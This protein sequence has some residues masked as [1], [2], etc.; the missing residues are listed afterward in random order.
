MCSSLLNLRRRHN[1]PSCL[2]MYKDQRFKG[3]H[4]SNE[5]RDEWKARKRAIVMRD[6]FAMRGV[7]SVFRNKV[8][9]VVH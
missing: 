2:Q 3:K 6:V 5:G 8:T 1:L 7:R 4:K 9:D